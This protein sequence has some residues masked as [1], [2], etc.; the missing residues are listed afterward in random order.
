MTGPTGRCTISVAD[1]VDP[2]CCSRCMLVG[3]KGHRIT[4]QNGCEKE[5]QQPSRGILA[6]IH[7]LNTHVVRILY[8]L[9]LNTT[10]PRIRRRTSSPWKR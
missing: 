3:Y 8:V 9:A 10:S 5:R 2:G 1:L 4:R 6:P 7:R